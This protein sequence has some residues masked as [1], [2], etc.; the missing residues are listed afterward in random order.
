M[1][2]NYTHQYPERTVLNHTDCFF[3]GEV[4]RFQVLLD[5]L[6]P[7]STRASWWSPPVLQGEAVKILAYAFAQCGQTWRNAMLGQWPKGVVA[8]V[9]ISRWRFSVFHD[10]DL[11]TSA[12][13]A[14]AAEFACCQDDQTCFSKGWGTTQPPTKGQS[15]QNTTL[16]NTPLFPCETC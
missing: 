12:I 4:I 10:S 14:T 9:S 15:P 11:H 5:S 2:Q 3:C 16:Y 13:Q 8:W 1:R 6:H 7:R